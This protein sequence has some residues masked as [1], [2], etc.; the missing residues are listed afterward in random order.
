MGTQN[1]DTLTGN[2]TLN[3]RIFGLASNDILIGGIGADFLDGGLGNDTMR[4]GAGNDIYVVDSSTD[5][6]IEIN[7]LAA[8]G[9]AAQRAAF[10]GIDTVESSAAT[11]TLANYVENLTLTGTGDING[12]G[13]SLDNIIIGNSGDNVLNGGA[14]IDTMSGG[15]GNDT[16]VVDVLGDVIVEADNGGTDTI[17]ASRTYS[18]DT[19][20]TAYV[21]NLTLTGTANRNGTGNALDNV[22][23][24]N[25]GNNTLNGGTAGADTLI[26]G[27]GNDIYV[28][29][30]AGVTV[31]ELVG[32]GTDTVQTSVTTTL[33]DNVENLTLTGTTAINGTGNAGNNIIIGND[34]DNILDA[35]TAGTD[36]LRGGLG[37]DTYIV[38]HAG[39]TVVETGAGTDTIQSSVDFTLAANVE[40]LTL[41]GSAAINGTG[42]TGANT[43][44]GN[45][46]A[47]NINGGGGAGVDTLIGGGGNDTYVV[48]NTGTTVVEATG[49]GTDT[50]QSSASFTLGANV[51]NLTLTGTG[52]TAATGNTDANVIVGNT[53]NNIIT[54]G[55]SAD[56]LTGG[57]GKD[58]FVVLAT[59]DSSVGASDVI[60]DFASVAA[61]GIT[62][63]D[64]INL[65]AIDA[66]ANVV[67]DQAFTFINT[68]AFSNVVG[69]LRYMND[70][71]N[72]FVLGDVNG[73]SI[74]DFAIQLSGL[75][76]LGATDFLL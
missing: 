2:A 6:V 20:A 3:N 1:I 36:I 59:T 25:S 22:I 76:T 33:S 13:N 21:E 12:T 18:L 64:R 17:L 37:N 19:T 75:H 72:T 71:T 5:I 74:A 70:G 49:G 11:Y 39:V 66:N 62:T 14:G 15:A 69:Q 8:V 16:Y 58:T 41:T 51:E 56:T 61:V 53:G 55:G 48:S 23:M 27:A 43:I 26:G 29:D 44:I 38:D 42:N 63:S 32:D 30:H 40:N 34:N 35:G 57:L 28:I 47:N 9:N 73:D 67:N 24:G 54:G 7:G 46:A 65:V 4:G 45:D 60:T 68:G 31:I 52:N 50:A 10:N